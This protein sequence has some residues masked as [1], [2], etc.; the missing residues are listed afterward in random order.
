MYGT[1]PKHYKREEYSIRQPEEEKS[2][3]LKAATNRDV[4]IPTE[5]SSPFRILDLLARVSASLRKI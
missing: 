3:P 4:S 1:Y 2:D 5:P